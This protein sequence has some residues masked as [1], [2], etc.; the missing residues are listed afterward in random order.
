[1]L[2]E[3]TAQTRVFQVF[4]EDYLLNTNEH[5]LAPNDSKIQTPLLLDSVESVFWAKESGNQGKAWGAAANF[6]LFTLHF[7]LK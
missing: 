4:F 3:H 6:S 5:E 7:S 2:K 1:M